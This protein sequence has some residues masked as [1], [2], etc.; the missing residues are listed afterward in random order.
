[1]LHVAQSQG[2]I[3]NLY[4]LLLSLRISRSGITGQSFFLG[5]IRQWDKPGMRAPVSPR[6]D[7]PISR[8]LIPLHTH[9]G[10]FCH[11][12]MSCFLTLYAVPLTH[13]S[14]E[15]SQLYVALYYFIL[16]L[17]F[18]SLICQNPRQTN[19]I[20]K[21]LMVLNLQINLRALVSLKYYIFQSMNMIKLSNYIYL[22]SVFEHLVFFIEIL[23]TFIIFISVLYFDTFVNN[24]FKLCFIKNAVAF[25]IILLL[26]ITVNSFSSSNN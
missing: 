22:F 15:M 4:G 25:L 13:S 17:E 24:T 21:I 16:V 9:E 20:F 19:K 5:C 10:H 18:D 26:T 23:K 6:M 2:S 7:F 11:K 12:N 1:M 3:N 8:I 14:S